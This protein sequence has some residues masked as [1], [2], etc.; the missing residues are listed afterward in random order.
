MK[1]WV[2]PALMVG[3]LILGQPAWANSPIQDEVS[4]LESIIVTNSGQKTK[5]LDTNASIHVITAKDIRN[6]GQS[7][8]AQ[9]IASIPGVVNQKSG[10]QTY[11]SIRGTRTGMSG[12]P[13][14]YLDGRPLNV[15][16]YDYS[17]IDSIPLNNIEKI[18]VIK[19]PSTSKYGASAA[20]G[21]ILITTKKGNDSDDAF[22]GM[23]SAEYGSWD[24][25]KL[26]AS[27]LGKK[28]RVDYSISAYVN[29]SDGYRN[30]D[31]ENKSVDGQ[32][33]WKFD[34]GRI[35][36][37][38]GFNDSFNKY[39]V[40]LAEWQV[41]QDRTVAASNTKE[42]GSGYLMLPNE[43]DENLFSTMVTIEYDKNDWLF[44][45]S[46]GFSRDEQ[47]FFYKKYLNSSSSSY[48]NYKDD[49]VENLYDVKVSVG[50]EFNGAK[51]FNTL[52]F[53]MDYKF[54]DFEQDRLY[55][56]DTTGKYDAKEAAA[57]IESEKKLF[58]INLNHE[59]SWDIYRLQSG[60]R[61][62]HVSYDLT[63]RTPNSI[64]VNYENDIDWSISPSVSVLDNANLF[65][66]WNHSNFYLPIGYYSSNMS[67]DNPNTR[68]EDLEPEIYDT[69]EGGW[70]HQFNKAFNYSLILYRT[71]VE[72]KIVSYYDTSD[73]FQGR[74]N[75]GTS[76]HQGIEAEVDGRPLD[77]LGYRIS[78][79]TIDAEWDKGQAK[80]YET[81]G[82]TYAVTDLSGKKV[83][84]VPDYEYTVGMD[85]YPVRNSRYG[86]LTIAL[87][88][89]GF[90]EQY[91]DYNNNL[92]MPAADFL[93][94]K[95]IW[96]LKGLEC[97]LTCSNIFDKEWDK[98]VNASGKA[99]SSFKTGSGF[100]PQDGRYIGF[101]VAYRF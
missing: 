76:I 36:W 94:A 7:S 29:E 23:V 93:D 53:G 18:E 58:G 13:K 4:V 54:S 5:L 33:G 99:H 80:A 2:I 67:Y 42:D 24:T 81:P 62:N 69:I 90:G 65:V 31:Q 79:T 92:K 15:G 61:Y 50:K 75:A 55:L 101:G 37:I 78:F 66:T 71:R 68:A 56:Y 82:G 46:V 74:H 88:L 72:D 22:N 86:S 41:E 16:V 17:K 49:R 28:E 32:I 70:K 48:K 52:S 51:F 84:Y 64:S 21:V 38:T 39:P 83:N 77:W 44:N 63:N 45:S 98:V 100:Y 59:L 1:T 60:L 43:S 91:E 89:R 19:S 57:D 26:N 87:D 20:R 85:F 11:L 30:D 27:V 40:G 25:K 10:S 96:A 73:D 35:D 8:T 97:Y 12:G 9:L 6:S 34:G 47:D 95:I 3:I 14:I